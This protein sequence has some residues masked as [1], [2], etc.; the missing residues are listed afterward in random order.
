MSLAR[1]KCGSRCV[2][3]EVILAANPFLRIVL[4][5]IRAKGG[6]YPILERVASGEALT[7]IA[8]DYEC[9]RHSLYK[10]LHKKEHLW[11]LFEEARRESAMALAEEG[12]DIIDELSTPLDDGTPRPVTREDVALAKERVA[13]RRWLAQSYDRETFGIQ[14]AEG[15]APISIG[16]LHLKVLMTRSNQKA[17]PSGPQSR[18]VEAE[19]VAEEPT[20][21]TPTPEP[22]QPERG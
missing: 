11:H 18:V 2:P 1:R 15:Q 8:K 13:Q 21:A 22:S 5:R 14:S 4:Q 10:L 9:S 3:P 20:N 16:S 17:L 19:L 7:K 12:T 6:W